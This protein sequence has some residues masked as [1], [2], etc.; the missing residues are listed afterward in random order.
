MFFSAEYSQLHHYW[1]NSFESDITTGKVKWK[2]LIL[3]LCTH[4]HTQKRDFYNLHK[5]SPIN[6][7]ILGTELWWRGRLSGNNNL[8]MWMLLPYTKK[9]ILFIWA[10]VMIFLCIFCVWNTW[11]LWTVVVVWKRA[12]WIKLWHIKP[13]Y[14]SYSDYQKHV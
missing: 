14:S 7:G 13:K 2:F 11:S 4:Q 5:L 8:N 9:Y 10:T 12:V 1:N 6:D 3:S